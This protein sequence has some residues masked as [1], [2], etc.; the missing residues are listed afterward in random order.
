MENLGKIFGSQVRI[1][2][3]RLFLFQQEEA[4]DIDD[5]VK[6]SKV[7]KDL[8]RREL[9]LLVKAGFLK[10]KTFFKK[11]AKPQSKT[12][13]KQG[14]PIE[15]KKLKKQG[16]IINAQYEL[17]QPF[18]ALL[19][20]SELIKEK[21]ISKKIRKTGSIKLIV[22]SGIFIH[23]H[24]RK[25]DLLIVGNNLKRDMLKKEIAHIESEVGRELSYAVFDEAE[26]MYRVRM[27]DKLIRDI[28][29]NR[30]KKI[31]NSII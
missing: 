11:I 6:R 28:L 26:F 14:K 12:A 16:W 30:H 22:L 23:D 9:S 25:V 17:I 13:E 27:Y 24:N 1:K 21:E 31:H 19:I 15:Y 8:A 20:E 10:K 3:M 4:F 7:K 5:I 29:E 18:E 2:I